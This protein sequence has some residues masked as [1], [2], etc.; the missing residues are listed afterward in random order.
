MSL[1]HINL[2]NQ[3]YIFNYVDSKVSIKLA[4]D[5]KRGLYANIDIPSGTLIIVDNA[6]VAI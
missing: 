5:N 6:L 2:R 1:S 3:A 4:N